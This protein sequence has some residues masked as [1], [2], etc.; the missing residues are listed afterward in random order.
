MNVQIENKGNEMQS[1]FKKLNILFLIRGYFLLNIFNFLFFFQVA[2]ADLFQYQY[3]S[4]RYLGRGDTGV[5]SA[6]GG[7]AMF[8]NPAGIAQGAQLI[9]ELVLISP[10]VEG[11]NN[12]RTVYS[13]INENDQAALV[14]LLQNTNKPFYL[15]AQNLTAVVFKRFAL[16]AMQRGDINVQAKQDAA[17]GIPSVSVDANFWNGAYMSVAKDYYNEQ[18]LI[19]AT[20][21]YIQKREYNISLTALQI[22]SQLQKNVLTQT[23]I[24]SERKAT[25]LG[26]DLGGMVILH[27][28][29][30]TQIGIVLRNLGMEYTLPSIYENKGVPDADP[31]EL[32]I[33]ATTS[34]GTKRG[35]LKLFV[36]Y[37]DILNQQMQDTLKHTHF[38]LEY[39]L[40]NIIIVMT[41]LNQGYP[42]YGAGLNFRIIRFESGIYTEEISDLAGQTA[43]TRY[44]A[45]LSIGWLI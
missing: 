45:R 11:S 1:V 37:K 39:N 27:K 5:A 19:G 12:V 16:G 8:Y 13:K 21:K 6:S 2:K 26:A 14:Y 34:F 18:I 42:S 24:D 35:R 9:N 23:F 10:Q 29:T 3:R 44:F 43:S 36:D 41:G 4:A 22:D 31:Q 38:G 25:G 28:E 20:G 7:D 32:N 30:E 15:A 40:E 17:T 33:G